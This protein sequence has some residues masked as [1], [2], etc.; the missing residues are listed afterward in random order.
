MP[1]KLHP[2]GYVARVTGLTPHLIRAW[3]RRYG[4]VN[5]D[6]SETNRRLYSDE[7]ILRLTALQRAVDSGHRIAQLARMTPESLSRLARLTPATRTGNGQSADAATAEDHVQACLSAVKDL[8]VGQLEKALGK[9]AAELPR[10][11][12]LED[13]VGVL[14]NRIGEMW[15]EGSLKILNEHMASSVIQSFLWDLLRGGRVDGD[16]PAI[17]V[18]TPAGQLCV[19]GALVAGVTAADLGWLVHFFGANL[20]AEEVA[21]AARRLRASAVALS[22]THRPE[23]TFIAKELKRL[24]HGLD[25]NVELLVGGQAAN[26][27]LEAI[28]AVGGRCVSHLSEFAAELQSLNLQAIADAAS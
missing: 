19:M 6:R 28:E 15:A 12:L 1:D 8:D 9:A 17:V 7:D 25:A 4:V 23:P 21:A 3:E 11:Q 27:T 16:Q 24:R 14:M 2:I 18:A 22:I 26:S 13:V 20:P 10:R 5:P